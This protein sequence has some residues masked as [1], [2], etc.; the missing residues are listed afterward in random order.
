MK[1]LHIL[2]T[3][4]AEGTPR[5]VLDWLAM[6][7]EHQQSVFCLNST[8]ADLSSRLKTSAHSYYE[9][10]LLAQSRL[11]KFPSI[12]KNTAKVVRDLQPDLTICWSGGFS[13]WVLAGARL[14]GCKKLIAHAGNPADRG[15]RGDFLTRY[16]MWPLTL[17]G[18]RVVCCS[19]YVRDSMRAV[20]GTR[21]D[22]FVTVRNCTRVAEVAERAEHARNSRSSHRPPTVVMIATLERHKDH[23]TLLHA[24]PT[25]LSRIPNL[26][27]LLAGDGTLRKELEKLA[28]ELELSAAVKFLGTRDDIP[29]LLG[30]ADLFVFSTTPREG[31]G[32]VLLEGLAAKL[33]IVASDVPACR[34]ILAGGRWGLLVP[35]ADPQ[36]LA[37]AIIR[38]LGEP[39]SA[40]ALNKAAKYA[41]AFTPQQ[42][43]SDYLA[44]AEHI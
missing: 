25:V 28:N 17:L 9:S 13:S 12:L 23:K 22:L 5:L 34:E 4:R 18:G 44:I 1:I 40:D 33:P 19:D 14:G 15:L 41:S 29:E 2:S 43:M 38:S 35:P 30:N 27:L 36:A 42:M 24:I 3:P 21:K 7:C 16:V 20:P 32:S 8:P 39:L 10:N 31:L 37:N 26:Q 6:D 11:Q